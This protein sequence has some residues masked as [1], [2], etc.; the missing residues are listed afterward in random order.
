MTKRTASSPLKTKS[1]SKGRTFAKKVSPAMVTAIIGGGQAFQPTKTVVGAEKRLSAFR[2]AAARR[3]KGDIRSWTL[4]S[5]LGVD[6]EDGERGNTL[7][8]YFIFSN[9]VRDGLPLVV[10]ENLKEA[11]V[12]AD[13]RNMII[14]PRTLQHRIAKGEPLSPVESERAYRLANV[15]SLA[16]QVF[17]NHEKSLRW[18]HKPLKALGGKAPLDVLDNEP[19]SRMVEDLLGRLDEGYFA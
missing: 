13:Y 6:D 15:I 16:D 18:L 1:G 5:L 11:G 7:K 12:E 17:G 14:P 4:G 10:M 8:A 9:L 19:G 3:K 2:A